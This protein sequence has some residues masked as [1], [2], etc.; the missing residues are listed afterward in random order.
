MTYLSLFR[1]LSE[2]KVP[3]SDIRTFFEGVLG[4]PLS[5]IGTEGDKEALS[6]KD[7]LPLKEKLLEGYPAVYLAGK[8]QI[9]GLVYFLT[10]DVLVPRTETIDFV[11][12]TLKE[13]KPEPS[14]ILD[15]CTGS[16]FISISLKSLFPEA[17]VTGSDISEAALRL[18]RKSAAANHLD[19]SFVRS[20]FLASVEGSYDWIVSNPPYIETSNP[21]VDAPF[22][23]AL[24]L[25]SGP[26]GLDSYR[27]IFPLLLSHLNPGG[28]AFFELEASNA[29]NVLTLFRSF[30][31][32]EK[33]KASF[34][35]DME[36]KKRYLRVDLT[37]CLA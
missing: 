25:Y 14:S 24:A 35:L 32:A 12:G 21:D 23:P 13:E 22:E 5:V 37:S 26:N 19:V 15:L 31:P 11:Y 27:A 18:A 16:G 4:K 3:L 1:D 8:D 10:P 9:R 6:E 17:K 30:V 7:Y 36:G 29:Q 34:L 2:A 33:A 20:D 28:K